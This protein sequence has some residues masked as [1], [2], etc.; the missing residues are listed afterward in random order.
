[1]SKIAVIGDKD[2]VLGFK[3]LGIEVFTP[4]EKIE[5]RRTIQRLA[6]SD[7]GVIFITEQLASISKQTIEKYDNKF[8]PA[9]IPIPSSQGTLNIGLDRIEENIEKAVGV[10][11]F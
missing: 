8:V 9:I 5:V 4:K 3:A 2:S 11:L 7:Y 6:Q 10:N 1:M